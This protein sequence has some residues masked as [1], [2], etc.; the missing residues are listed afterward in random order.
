MASRHGVVMTG[1]QAWLVFGDWP[2]AERRE[3]LLSRKGGRN[4]AAA[5]WRDHSLSACGVRKARHSLRPGVVGDS[6]NLLLLS[7]P[8]PYR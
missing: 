6:W 1:K 4:G 8:S 7:L 3:T 5:G 2:Q